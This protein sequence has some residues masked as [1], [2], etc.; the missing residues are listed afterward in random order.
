MGCRGVVRVLLESTRNNDA[1]DFIRTCF[2][3]REKGAITTLISKSGDVG[4]GLASRMF[5]EGAIG[6]YRRKLRGIERTV[7]ERNVAT[8]SPRL[9]ENRSRSVIYP[10][11]NGSLEFFHE[12]INPPTAMLY[13]R[14]GTRCSAAC[15]AGCESRLEDL[16]DRSPAGV[17]RSRKIPRG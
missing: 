15:A 8:R 13:L 16:C 7:V 10:D 11:A 9:D 14:R 4:L 2:D 5:L 3:R 12:V 1:L 6:S 17:C